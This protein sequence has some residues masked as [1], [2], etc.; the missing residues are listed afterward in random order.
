MFRPIV[1]KQLKKIREMILN[2]T[3]TFAK[4]YFEKFEY[5]SENISKAIVLILDEYEEDCLQKIKD[6]FDIET[7]LFYSC[8]TKLYRELV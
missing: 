6:F 2:A 8:T 5:L 4:E 3:R 1:E 7:S